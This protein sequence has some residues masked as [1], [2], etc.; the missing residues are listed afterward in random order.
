MKWTSIEAETF[1]K[2][3][4]KETVPTSSQSVQRREVDK[5]NKRKDHKSEYNEQ[6]FH[7][8]KTYIT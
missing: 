2:E 3:K 8:C 5:F 7:S 4:E 1:S 6:T